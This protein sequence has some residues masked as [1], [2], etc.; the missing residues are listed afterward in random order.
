M[1]DGSQLLCVE[2]GARLQEP[3]NHVGGGHGAGGHQVVGGLEGGRGRCA[4]VLEFLRLQ[5]LK[6]ETLTKLHKF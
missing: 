2:D 6:E 4:G 3:C 1:C 5:T